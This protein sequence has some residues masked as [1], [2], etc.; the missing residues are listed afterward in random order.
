MLGEL[1][2]QETGQVTAIR[3]LPGGGEPNVEVSFQAAGT[4]LGT[5]ETNIGTYTTVTRP[6]GTLFGEGQGVVM[7]ES[8][9]MASWKGEGVGHFTGEGTAVSWRG[10]IFYQTEAQSLARLNGLATVF[11]YDTDA[12]G[13]TDAR[14]YEW[15]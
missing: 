4:L 7:T 12:S 6:D 13:K 9:D 3:V 2:G 1:V 11:E 15:K 10:A 5:N 14:T 8:G